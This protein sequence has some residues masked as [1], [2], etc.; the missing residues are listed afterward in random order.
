MLPWEVIRKGD[1]RGRILADKHYTRQTPGHPMWTRPGYN[2]CLYCEDTKGGAVFVWWRPKW[3]ADI[4]RKDKL[5]CLECTIFRNETNWLSSDLVKVA[6]V[7][8]ESVEAKLELHHENPAKLM[9]ITGVGSTKTI[10]GRSSKSLP[11]ACFR[12]AGWKDFDHKSGKADVWLT[13]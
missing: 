12:Y 8:L 11:G 5:R 4:E 6:V 3:E 13:I 1:V 10:R 9:L 7:A 2:F